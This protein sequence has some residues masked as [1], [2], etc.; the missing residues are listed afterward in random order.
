MN[1]KSKWQPIATAPQD[2]ASV[3]LFH[4][5]WDMF[6]VGVYNPAVGRWQERT[7]DLLETPTHWMPLPPPPIEQADSARATNPG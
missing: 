5:A 7:G 4:P 1:A 6:E 2:G 3:L